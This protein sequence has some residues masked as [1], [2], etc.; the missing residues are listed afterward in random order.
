MARAKPHSI[1]SKRLF[2]Q[3]DVALDLGTANTLIYTAD[4]GI[5]LNQPSVVCFERRAGASETTVAA[6]GREAKDLLGR[7]PANLETVR[8][9]SHGVIANF[10]AAEHMM[11]R[12][13]AMAQ[14]RRLLGRRAAFTVCV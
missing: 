6:V 9:L 14:P 11:R 1:F 7:T 2:R 4:K 10:S 5:V 8:P 13:V 12:F 3:E